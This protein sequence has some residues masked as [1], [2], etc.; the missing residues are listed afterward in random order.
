MRHSTQP[1]SLF[2]TLLLSITVLGL[3]SVLILQVVPLA[4]VVPPGAFCKNEPFGVEAQGY[5]WA[6]TESE[7]RSDA[8]ASALHRAYDICENGYGQASLCSQQGPNCKAA[9]T[10]ALK[11]PGATTAMDCTEGVVQP[12]DYASYGYRCLATVTIPCLQLCV[13][14]APPGH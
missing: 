13:Y 8:Y 2:E 14:K 9:G 5:G 4:Q 1:D 7:A 10:E 11:G 12:P 6:F 3:L